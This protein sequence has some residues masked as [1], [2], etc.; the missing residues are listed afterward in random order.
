MA[1]VGA[2][3][4]GITITHMAVA[5]TVAIT[6]S[7]GAGIRNGTTARRFGFD[8]FTRSTNSSSCC[9]LFGSKIRDIFLI[10]LQKDLEYK[11]VS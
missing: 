5:T 7:I 3:V 11:C 8:S 10:V 2:T 6:T 4:A 9:I 1:V